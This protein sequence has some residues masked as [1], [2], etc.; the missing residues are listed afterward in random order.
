MV[1]RSDEAEAMAAVGSELEVLTLER[2][3]ALER[4]KVAEVECD[5]LREQ[6]AAQ[7]KWVAVGAEFKKL[8]LERDAALERAKLAEDECDVLRDQLAELDAKQVE[9]KVK[10]PLRLAEAKQAEASVSVDEAKVI[11]KASPKPVTFCE[12]S[13]RWRDAKGRYCRA[14]SPTPSP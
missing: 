7:R 2:D 8:V 5:V 9:A 10:Y 13:N 14:P 6:L 4:A 11:R 3:A 12:R 1:R